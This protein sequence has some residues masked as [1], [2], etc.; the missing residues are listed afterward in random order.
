MQLP[1]S[2][3]LLLTA[4]TNFPQMTAA[5]VCVKGNVTSAPTPDCATG[6]PTHEVV[7]SHMMRTQCPVPKHSRESQK[8]ERRP[9]STVYDAE[10]AKL[11]LP[12]LTGHV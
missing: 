4:T 5:V 10:C 11:L 7:W 8:H 2:C 12:L 1:V 6:V 3:R 9:R